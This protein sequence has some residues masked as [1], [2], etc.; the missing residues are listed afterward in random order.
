MAELLRSVE[1]GETV[2]ITRHGKPIAHMSP[3]QNLEQT[4]R[5]RAVHQLREWRRRRQPTGKNTEQVL[6]LIREGRP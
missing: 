5:K 3:A 1:C 4:A 2:T 6:E